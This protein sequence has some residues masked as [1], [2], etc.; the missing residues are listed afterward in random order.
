MTESEGEQQKLCDPKSRP[1]RSP[2]LRHLRA[3][4]TKTAQIYV[5]PAHI[6]ALLC[7]SDVAWGPS[8]EAKTPAI[9]HVRLAG[10]RMAG[11][12]ERT[13]QPMS[14]PTSADLDVATTTSASH[15]QTATTAASVADAWQNSRGGA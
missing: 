2:H 11:T 4:R 3:C 1:V 10:R 13:A 5:I 8:R 15:E 7:S 14:A 12:R 6:L 9:A